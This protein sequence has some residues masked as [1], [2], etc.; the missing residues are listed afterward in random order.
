MKAIMVM[1]D[2]L[3]RHMLSPYGCDW[4]H[5]PNF[6]RLAE[7]SAT[8]ERFYVGSMPCMPAR[9]EL[10][11]GRYNFLHRGWGPL[12]PFDDS[13]IEMLKQNAVHT[14]L[15]SD[16]YHYWEEGGATYHTRYG[17]WEISRGQE[18]DPW[19]GNLTCEIDTEGRLEQSDTRQNLVNRLYMQDEA[20]TS[21]AK[22]YAMGIEFIKTNAAADKWFLQIETFDPHEPFVVP[23]RYVDLYDD[24]YTGGELDHPMYRDVRES[25]ELVRHVRI[26]NAALV[27]M[28]D[29]YLGQVLDLMDSLDLWKDTMLIVTTDH[30]FLLGEHDCWGKCW[31]PFY[32][33]ISHAP[34][35]V[36]DPRCGAAGERRTSL[37]QTIDLGP[38]L[39]EYFGLDLTPDMQGRPLRDTVARDAPIRRAGLFGVFGSHVCVTDGRYVYMRAPTGEANKPLYEYTHMPTHMTHTFSPA[40]MRTATMVDRTRAYTI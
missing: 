40:D 23:K 35:F 15:V 8:F 28:C 29:H 17:S 3:N 33:E 2:S 16:H 14:H 25:A 31:C 6:R 19:K 38:T 5:A 9:R 32:E 7:R 39:L 27:S 12:E 1:F 30:G 11:T 10:H 22:T 21:Q 37:A 24:E 18:Y 4:V 36:W 20:D 34:L 26:L 13:S